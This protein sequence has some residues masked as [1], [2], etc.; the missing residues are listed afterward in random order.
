MTFSVND[1]PFAG[2]EGKY[3]TSRHLRDRLMRE[4][5]KDVSLRVSETDTTESF[6]VSGRGEMHLS[7]LIENMRREGYEFAVGAPKALLREID[8]KLCEPVERVVM[9]VPADAVGSVMSKLSSRKG[10][11]VQMS[12]Y[13]RPHEDRI[14]SPVARPFR[15]P[16]RN[17][18]R[19][20][21]RGH[22]EYRVRQLHA[23]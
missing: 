10:E 3:V 16:Q 14:F 2:R 21:R 18:H 6:K 15:L 13:G 4:L 17:A 7:I 20:A 8:G 23:L 9:D 19:Y 22:H 12:P 11:L 5:L 1:S